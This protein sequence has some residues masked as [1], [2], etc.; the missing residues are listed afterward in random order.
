MKT[1][2]LIGYPLGHSFSAR[3]FA[4][5]FAQEQIVDCQYLNFPIESIDRLP[6]M[7]EQEKNLRGFNVT[8]PYKQAVFAYL[9]D[10]SDEARA[11]GAVNCVKIGPNGL[12]GFNTDAYG[13]SRSLLNLIG[14][15]RP[16]ALV[17]GTGGASKA[18][19]YVLTQLGIS[20]RLVSRQ[21]GS[22]RLS[23]AEVTSELIHQTPLIINATPLGTFPNVK[24]CPDIPYQ[25][26][27]PDHS[28]FDLVYNP[29]VT[30]F[31]KRGA[32]QGAHTQNGYDMLIGQAEKA[33]EIW[34]SPSL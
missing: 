5:K 1:Y 16:Q 17:L 33:W 28:L 13:F 2:G 26:L 31:L 3:Y 10:L 34:N 24:D 23:Y 9:D 20:H 19:C 14:D 7:L 29:A 15:R 21:S 6:E 18:V 27:G 30:E 4:D 22:N 12:K 25:A 11:I 8:I 32:D